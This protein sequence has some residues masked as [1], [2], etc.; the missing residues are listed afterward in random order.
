MTEINER[1]SILF[2]KPLIEIYDT[3]SEVIKQ[4][5]IPAYLQ[6]FRSISS[7]RITAVKTELST[8]TDIAV[9]T[10]ILSK[11]LIIRLFAFVLL[12]LGIIKSPLK[13]IYSRGK[14]FRTKSVLLFF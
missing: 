7:L 6:M 2:L 3:I 5:T 4:I 11:Y 14:F 13:L 8:K 1:V 10:K 12:I 9:D